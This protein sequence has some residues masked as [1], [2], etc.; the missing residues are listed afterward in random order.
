MIGTKSY[1]RGVILWHSGLGH[2]LQHG[3]KSQP[4]HVFFPQMFN[5]L[6][7]I[8]Y[9]TETGACPY[10]PLMEVGGSGKEECGWDKYLF[11]FFVF[12]LGRMQ[13]VGCSFLSKYIIN[14]STSLAAVQ[15]FR[16]TVMVLPPRA[17][18]GNS[19]FSLAQTWESWPFGECTRG[20]K[21]CF[22]LSLCYSTF[23]R[24]KSFFLNC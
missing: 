8:V 6:F 18:P 1:K 12:L 14:C 19:C 21:I 2:S 9:L 20:S 15:Y 3:F 23:Q 4:L 22:S 7:N 16:V 24:H 11:L 5:F 13:Q 17:R 10:E